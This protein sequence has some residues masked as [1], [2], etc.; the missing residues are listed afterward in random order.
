MVG[1][2]FRSAERRANKG[3]S[4]S[5]HISSVRTLAGKAALSLQIEMLNSRAIHDVRYVL[6]THLVIR[7]T[8]GGERLHSGAA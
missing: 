6:E 4:A 3:L 7:E 8:T 5:C 1:R 2:H